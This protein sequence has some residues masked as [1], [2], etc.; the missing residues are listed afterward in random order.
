MRVEGNM[1]GYI[2][3]VALQWNRA[4][5]HYKD[6]DVCELLLTALETLNKE[7]DI[8]SCWT[9]TSRPAVNARVP[10]WHP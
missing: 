5:G 10:Q 4:G 3:A 9:L 2:V 1:L 6:G 7:N 8:G